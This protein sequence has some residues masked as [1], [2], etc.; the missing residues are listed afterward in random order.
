MK[1]MISWFFTLAHEIAVRTLTL[2]SSIYLTC[3]LRKHNLVGPHTAEHSY[4]MNQI[5]STH[6]LSLIDE[7]Q[8]VQFGVGVE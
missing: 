8:A 1:A 2:L 4:Y 3:F 5:S 7:L 6:I